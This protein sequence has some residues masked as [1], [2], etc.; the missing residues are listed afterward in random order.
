MPTRHRGVGDG[1]QVRRDLERI[2]TFLWEQELGSGMRLGELPQYL[3]KPP[4]QFSA[5]VYQKPTSL[6][7][8]RDVSLSVVAEPASLDLLLPVDHTLVE[9][10]CE[11]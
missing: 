5:S 1:A 9:G 3:P 4:R 11:W 8:R 2:S 10:D 6:K 7:R